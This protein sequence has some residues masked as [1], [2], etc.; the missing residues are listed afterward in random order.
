MLH[1][2]TEFLHGYNDPE[3]APEHRAWGDVTDPR[4]HDPTTF[5]YLV[6]SLDP[7]LVRY[8]LE[9]TD[10]EVRDQNECQVRPGNLYWRPEA[11]GECGCL[12]LSLIDPD[13]AACDDTGLIVEASEQSVVATTGAWNGRS[14]AGH[15]DWLV[16]D[17]NRTI[18]GP[19]ELLGASAPDAPN[20]VLVMTDSDSE[21][22]DTNQVSLKGFFYKIDSDGKPYSRIAAER[23]KQHAAQLNLPVV[24]IKEESR[25]SENR[26]VINDET[27][28][29][30]HSG[31]QYPIVG[32]GDEHL[33]RAYD[34]KGRSYFPSPEEIGG[35]V[36]F[37]MQQNVISKVDVEGMVKRYIAINKDR[38]TPV[39]E[40][41]DDG[42][43]KSIRYYEGYGADEKVVTIDGETALAT[44][45]TA[46]ATAEL[47]D[48]EML[49]EK[50][51]VDCELVAPDETASMVE[52]ACD[53]LDHEGAWAVR[54]W[55]GPKREAS[56][57]LWALE[58]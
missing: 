9:M 30:C 37:A 33:F 42:S 12:P 43:V 57:A 39:I 48:R 20:E 34:K 36:S 25:Y 4:E 38:Q 2:M 8:A 28:A 35:A 58:Q 3:S 18:M 23:M 56:R 16:A 7:E 50:R 27:I 47:V 55:Y 53:R 17:T 44:R 29:V 1:T 49:R 5:R 14:D 11:L 54:R 21:Q 32:F 45:M 26:E 13:H 22:S 19:D 24:P 31:R 10:R 15:L 6:C 51:S 52:R 46:S 40:F 41:G